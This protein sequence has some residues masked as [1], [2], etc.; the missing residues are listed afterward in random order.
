MKRREFIT[1][2]G[3]RC[4]T[5]RG[6][7]TAVRAHAADQA[8]LLYPQLVPDLSGAAGKGRRCRSSRIFPIGASTSMR[9]S[10]I[11]NLVKTAN[12]KIE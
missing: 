8:E 3:G 12:I 2:L 9:T 7:S 1:L 6:A 11:G 5:V 10:G 4:L